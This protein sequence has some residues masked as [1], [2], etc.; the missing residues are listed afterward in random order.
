[1][2]VLYQL[3]Q[4]RNARETIPFLDVHESNA[5]LMTQI[6]SLQSKCDSLERELVIQQ[7]KLESLNSPA[8]VRGG[9][10]AALKKRSSTS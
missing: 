9:Q 7:E 4:E 1:M 10:S 3:V 5:R 2:E 6:D 8:N